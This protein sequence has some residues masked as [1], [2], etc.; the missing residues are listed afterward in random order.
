M[1]TSLA[2]LPAHKQS[3]LAAIAERLKG[4]VGV[5]MVI[6]FG[7]HARSDW[8]DDPV[9][10]YHS[11]YDLL[12]VVATPG[13]AQRITNSAEVQADASALAG[14]RPVTLLVHDIKELNHQIRLGQFFFADILRD[15]IALHDTHR[16]SLARPKALTDADRLRLGLMNYRYWFDSASSFWRISF[17]C[18]GQGLLAPAAFLLHQSTERFFHTA[19]LVFTG[20][21]PKSHDI[22]ALANQTAPLH[23]ALEGAL[24]RTSPEDR[25]LFLLLK[26]AYI[27]A[28]Y[29]RSFKVTLD[30]LAALRAHVLDLAARVRAA[31]AAALQ[32]FAGDGDIGPLQDVPTPTET[33]PF[34]SPPPVDDLPAFEAWRQSLV[35]LTFE[36]GLEQGEQQGFERG[37]EHGQHLGQQQALFTILAARGIPLSPESRARIESCRDLATLTLWLSRVAIVTTAPELF[38]PAPSAEEAS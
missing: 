25:P 1:K 19:L 7:S 28:R 29:S 11:D 8:V 13:E 5:E 32:G 38:A 27:E 37:V 16:L 2:H 18:A 31:C 14:G 4:E 26:R 17:Q 35:D 30:E 22:E 36:R 12:L 6:L 20:Y 34:A 21:K 15:G 9:G 10:H 24:P 33:P 23:P 3:E